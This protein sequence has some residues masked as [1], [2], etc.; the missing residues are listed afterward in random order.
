MFSKHLCFNQKCGGVCS[1]LCHCSPLMGFRP[2]NWRFAAVDQ[3]KNKNVPLMRENK[4]TKIT[5]IIRGFHFT[6]YHSV[7]SA[8][9]FCNWIIRTHTRALCICV[10]IEQ[11]LVWWIRPSLFTIFI[12]P[13]FFSWT[14]DFFLCFLV[15]NLKM[16]FVM[17]WWLHHH[18]PSYYFFRKK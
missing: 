1:R 15:C 3:S 18:Q 17:T 8:L 13:F 4:T 12:F 11:I 2:M 10:S 9:I 6:N 14:A 16:C 5:K 7:F